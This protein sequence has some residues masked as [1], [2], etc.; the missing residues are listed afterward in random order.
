MVVSVAN[1]LS[2]SFPRL[3]RSSLGSRAFV[4]GEAVSPDAALVT[5]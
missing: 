4:N 3:Q 2:P 5:R 1:P